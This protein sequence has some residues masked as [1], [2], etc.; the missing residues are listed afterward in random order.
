MAKFSSIRK[1]N[2]GRRSRFPIDDFL[3]DVVCIMVDEVHKAKADVLRN[4]L[5]GVFAMFLF[6][7]D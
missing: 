6:V 7:G 2:K 1:E 5:S 4:L 3:D